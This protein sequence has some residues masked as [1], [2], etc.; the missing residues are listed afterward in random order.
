MLKGKNGGPAD[1]LIYLDSDLL[2]RLKYSL[3]KF[4]LCEGGGDISVSM[5]CVCAC[6]FVLKDRFN[7]L[8]I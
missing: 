2:G 3:E 8:L 6:A 5:S 7:I 4:S 1:M